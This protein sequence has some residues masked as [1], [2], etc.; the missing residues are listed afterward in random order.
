MRIYSIGPHDDVQRLDMDVEQQ[1]EVMHSLGQGRPFEGTWRPIRVGRLKKPRKRRSEVLCDLT[2]V[3]AKLNVPVLSAG[4]KQVFE[5]ILGRQ[6]Q[7]LPLAF[8]EGEYWLLNSLHVLD[9]LDLAQSEI[10]HFAHG[11]VWNVETYAFRISAVADEWLFKVANAP[12]DVLVTDRFRDL[13]QHRGLTGFYFQP[14]WDSEHKPFRIFAGREYIRT[15]PEVFGPEGFVTNYAEF[16]PPEW[17]E[18][19]RHLKRG[20]RAAGK[21]G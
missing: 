11:P 12:Y 16:W 2:A 6:A 1:V 15:R 3:A 18:Q 4:A 20:A 19:A 7:W 17:K 5:P 8:D 13:V 14:V 21:Q 9:A 10:R